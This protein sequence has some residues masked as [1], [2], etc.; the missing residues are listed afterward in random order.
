M[1]T[2]VKQVLAKLSGKTVNDSAN[3]MIKEIIFGEVKI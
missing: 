1:R 3:S 2:E